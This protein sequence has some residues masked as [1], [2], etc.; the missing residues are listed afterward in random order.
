MKGGAQVTLEDEEL[1][2]TELLLAGEVDASISAAR[3]DIYAHPGAKPAVRF[4]TIAEDLKRRDFSI[5]AI[6]ISLNVNSSRPSARS[7]QRACRSRSPRNSGFIH[8]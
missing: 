8:S 1:Q 4:S 2:S 7:R 5:N 3:E 6:A